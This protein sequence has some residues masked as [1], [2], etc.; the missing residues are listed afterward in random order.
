M[1][2]II[3]VMPSLRGGGTERVVSVLANRLCQG[4]YKIMIALTKEDQCEYELDPR[5]ICK[6]NPY[7]GQ[8]SGQLRF[9]RSLMKVCPEAT[10]VSLATYQNMYTLLTGMGKK[11][12]IIISERSAPAQTLYGRK[13]LEGLRFFL[14][15]RAQA[16]VFQTEE[17]M[18]YFPKW[19]QNKGVL[20]ENPL[21]E[22]LPAA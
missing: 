20:I 1:K 4:N 21:S 6:A 10:F 7:G 2:Q 9:L 11:R 12:R 18:R 15:G 22:H 17:A 16:A 19:I 3:F 13:Y 14:Y 5:V 8:I